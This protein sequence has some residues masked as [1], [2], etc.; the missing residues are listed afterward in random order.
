M[1]TAIY[2]LIGVLMGA[3]GYLIGQRQTRPEVHREAHEKPLTDEQI[4]RI[5]KADREYNNFMKYNGDAQGDD[6]FTGFTT[7]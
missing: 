2:V 6:E 7:R 4:A 5:R 1:T 3:A